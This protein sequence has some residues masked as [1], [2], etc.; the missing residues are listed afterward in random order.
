[1]E[2][3]A[4]T[5]GRA[6]CEKNEAARV[7]MNREQPARML[8]YTTLGFA[9]TRCPPEIFS[10]LS[11]WYHEYKDQ[12]VPESWPKGNTYTNHWAS[13][14]LMVSLE[15]RRFKGGMALKKDIWD[16]TQSHLEEWSGQKLHPT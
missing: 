9:K 1:M 14:T 10:A 7:E 11:S 12:R 5:Y 16:T 4:D 3:C 2:G 13:P 6:M 15:E 8:N